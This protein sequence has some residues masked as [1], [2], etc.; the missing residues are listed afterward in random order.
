MKVNVTRAIEAF[1]G[2]AG[3]LEFENECVPGGEERGLA[4]A[5]GR[6]GFVGE[7]GLVR[8][9][10]ACGA[11]DVLQVETNPSVPTPVPVLTGS[12]AADAKPNTLRS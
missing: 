2:D 1:C 11:C 10:R 3:L 12:G 9:N 6:A 4:R 7:A 8:V 5:I